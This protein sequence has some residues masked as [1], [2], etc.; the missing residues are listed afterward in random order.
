MTVRRNVLL[1]AVLLLSTTTFA[2]HVAEGSYNDWDYGP[3]GVYGNLRLTKAT[4][5]TFFKIS[6]DGP[7]KVVVRQ[8]NPSGTVINTATVTFSNGVL[9][10]VDQ[11]NQ[12]GEVYEYRHFQSKEKDVFSVTDLVRGRNIFLPAKYALFMYTG[13][14]LSEV[15]YCSSDGQLREDRNGVAILKYKRYTDSIR[16]SERQETSFFD[17]QR[18]PVLSK[19]VSYHKLLFAYDEHDNKITESCAGIHDEPMMFKQNGVGRVQYAYD[20]DNNMILEEYRDLADKIT[21]NV[22]G[23]ARIG[24]TYEQGYLMKASRSDSL[25]HPTRALAAGDGFSIIHYEYDNAGN[26]TRESFFDEQEKPMNNQ[27]GVQE[28]A[29]IYSPDHLLTRIT[30]FDQSGNPC[31]NRDNINS[32]VYVRDAQ[33][34]PI[35]ESSYG[36]YGTPI[37]TFTEQVYMIKRKFDQY[38]REI[39]QSYWADS[40]TRMKHWNGYYEVSTK[41]DADG[42]V[43]ENA[44]FDEHGAPLRGED[45]SS[46]RKLV[47][48]ADGR[49][50]ERQFLYDNKLINRARGVTMNYGIIRYGYDSSNRQTELTFW[51]DGETPANGTILL[52][53]SVSAHRILFVYKGNRIVQQ[54]YYKLDA[55]EPFMVVDCLKSDFIGLSGIS[56]G[57]KNEN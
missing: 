12:W 44:N 11:A 49:L 39:S 9:S 29:Y 34:R 28:I 18:Q 31:V 17:A 55:Q 6:K 33:N 26:R 4:A 22:Y 35:C 25:G 47:Y 27:T 15:Q 20:S 46:V 13:E 37:K 1:I 43:I 24:R 14:L 50:E 42:L 36:V 32:T 56:R 7:Q 45:G 53:D 54:K 41:Y 52:E 48:N 51:A 38:G 23:V 16:F 2:Q 8:L 3:H 30:Y 5:R 57:R 19:S 40:S 21:T 10:E